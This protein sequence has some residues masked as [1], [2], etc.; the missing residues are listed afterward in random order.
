MIDIAKIK[1]CF[2]AG[3][4]GQ[5]GAERQL[6]YILKALK[7]EGAH[8]DVIC[9]TQGETYEEKIKGLGINVYYAGGAP[10]RL[11]RL[12]EIINILKKIRPDILQSQHFYTNIYVAAASKITGITGIGASRNNLDKEIEL[13]GRILGRLSFWLPKYFIANSKESIDIA[14]KLGKSPKRV[15]YLPNGVDTDKFMPSGHENDIIQIIN[16]GRNVGFKRQWLFINLI[17][18][19]KKKSNIKIQGHLFGDGPEHESL[20]QLANSKGLLPEEM[21]FHGNTTN[22][23]V[24]LQKSDIFVLTSEY[25]GTPN[26]VLEAMACGLAVVCTAVGNLPNIIT[27]NKNG[28]L[29]KDKN[30]G[31]ELY[32]KVLYLINNKEFRTEMGQNAR[33]TI[34]EGFSFGKLAEILKN[35]YSKIQ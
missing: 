19:I 20:M 27:D 28:F 3:T 4:L 32:L 10:S 23:E 29:V 18:D 16:V 14:L 12:V 26:V 25:E 9:L 15:F 31:G 7:N 2:L 5:G 22:P 6:F 11:R 33:K 17:D 13:N 35:I 1:I 8:I 21:V 30:I 24:F 34:L